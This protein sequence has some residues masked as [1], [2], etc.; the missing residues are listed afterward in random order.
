M[1]KVYLPIVVQQEFEDYFCRMQLAKTIVNQ[2]YSSMVFQQECETD[3]FFHRNKNL[4]NQ[5]Y[6]P[7][8]F[9]QECEV[10]S[11]SHIVK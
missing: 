3:H 6:L 4:V 1:K 8:V 7:I 5:V 2:V 9:Q 10:G 11:F